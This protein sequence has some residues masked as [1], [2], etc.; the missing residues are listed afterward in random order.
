MQLTIV[1][2][3]WL[4]RLLNRTNSEAK[5]AR[6]IPSKICTIGIVDGDVTLLFLQIHEK[7]VRFAMMNMKKVPTFLELCGKGTKSNP[8]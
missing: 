7:M 4:L 1:F 6:D 2:K 8:R 5:T 3:W